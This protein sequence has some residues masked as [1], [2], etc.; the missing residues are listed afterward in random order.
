MGDVVNMKKVG[1]YS[2]VF[3]CMNSAGEEAVPVT[4]TV[5]VEHFI[6]DGESAICEVDANGNTHVYYSSAQHPSFKCTHTGASCTCTQKHPTHHS[7]GCQQFESK[8]AGK[9]LTHAGDCTESGKDARQYQA[10][11]SKE[12]RATAQAKCKMLG[13][14]WDLAKVETSAEIA[15]FNVA[16][17]GK[18]PLY[19][20][21]TCTHLGGTSYQWL[22]P[23]GSDVSNNKNK[24]EVGKT[25]HPYGCRFSASTSTTF[26]GCFDFKAYGI[27]STY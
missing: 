26:F 23:D 1:T 6:K 21:A 11:T 3:H 16:A 24:C 12:H 20:G 7:G 19:M 18:Y 4:R 13:A 15:D 8:V 17:A 5:N 25:G 14:N 2:V 27:C 9:L 10:V 22:Y